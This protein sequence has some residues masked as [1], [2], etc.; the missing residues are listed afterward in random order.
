MTARFEGPDTGS[1]AV[2]VDRA[3]SAG[4]LRISQMHAGRKRGPGQPRGCRCWP[5][6][7][8]AAGGG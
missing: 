2:G 3:A 1:G 5:G 6:P 8:W 7:W 4:G